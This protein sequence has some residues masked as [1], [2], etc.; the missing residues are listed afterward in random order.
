MAEEDG[1]HPKALLERPELP[2]HLQFVWSAWWELHTDRPMGMAVG[3]IPFTAIDRYASRF[4]VDD[5]DHFEAFREAVR[6]IDGTYLKWVNER[7]DSRG[8]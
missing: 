5:A 3:P 4:G 7:R 2:D 8:G 6:G 1:V